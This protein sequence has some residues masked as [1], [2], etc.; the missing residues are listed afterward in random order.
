MTYYKKIKK[1]S[2]SICIDKIT[3]GIRSVKNGHRTGDSVGIDLEFFFNKLEKL[4]QGMYD[5][6]YMQYCVA[7]LEAEQKEIKEIH[8]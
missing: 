8:S 4:N 6:L 7:R 3:M 5:D 2:E 1:S